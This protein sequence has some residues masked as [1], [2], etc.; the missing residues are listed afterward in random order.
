M[1][2]RRYTLSCK[3][4]QASSSRRSKAPCDTLHER[5]DAALGDRDIV[6]V[7]N[8]IDDAHGFEPEPVYVVRSSV[9]DNDAQD[10]D[11]LYERFSEVDIVP[12]TVLATTATVAA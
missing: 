3:P 11:L 1:I 2:N 12:G 9:I 8:W 6:L 7:G 4:N 10:W 5:L